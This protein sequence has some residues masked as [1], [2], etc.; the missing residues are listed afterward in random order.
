MDEIFMNVY[1]QVNMLVNHIKPSK[2][3]FIAV[4][5]VAPRAKANNQRDRRY[6][7]A[8][9][10][11]DSKEFL[12]REMQV[13]LEA[14]AMK[15]NSISPGT[16]FMFDLM[17]K[18]RF[19]IERKIHEDPA[20]RRLE[21][22]FSGGDVPGE[23]EQKIMEWIRG[24]KQSKDFDINESHCIYSNDADLVFLA[25]GLHLPKV[26]LV[27]E[28]RDFP[29]VQFSA[30]VRR[31]QPA[32][33][34]EFLFINLL[35]E[36][37]ELEFLQD[38]HRYTHP[39]DFERIIDD[40]ILVSFF[41]GNDFLHQL[42]CMSTKRGNYD[43]LLQTFKATLPTL[44]GY[45]SDKG[46]V[47]WKNFLVL[48]H[49]LQSLEPVMIKTTSDEMKDAV[50]DLGRNNRLIFEDQPK[51]LPQAPVEASAGALKDPPVAEPKAEEIAEKEKPTAKPEKRQLVYKGPKN[52]L[53]NKEKDQQREADEAAGFKSSLKTLTRGFEIRLQQSYLK[54]KEESEYLKQMHEDF[55]TKNPATIES[56]KMSLYQ[57]FFPVKS[58][59]DV[60]QVCLKYLEGV[61]F[62][63]RYYLQSCPSWTWYYPYILT[64][65]LSDLTATLQKHVLH[66]EPKFELS[67]PYKP[68]KQLCFILPR[69]SFGLL[70]KA[71][72]DKVLNDARCQNY[73]PTVISQL[74]PLD[75]VNE[76]QLTPIL[77][78]IIDEVIDEVISEIQEADL[79]EK[80]RFRNQLGSCWRFRYSES[81]EPVLFTSD[82]KGLPDFSESI[83]IEQYDYSQKYPID[84]SKLDYSQA[85]ATL[86][87]GFPSLK[88]IPSVEGTLVE[89]K[90]RAGNFMKMQLK[91]Y[92]SCATIPRSAKHQGY[93][94]YDYPFRKV[95][96]V[97]S[98]LTATE[99]TEDCIFGSPLL[100]NC[101]LQD[102]EA[103]FAYDMNK[104]IEKY[105]LSE[106][107]RDK[108]I[109]Y[110]VEDSLD[111]YYALAVRTAA[112][113]SQ[114][115]GLTFDFVPATEVVPQGLVMPFSQAAFDKLKV[116]LK[117]P[118]TQPDCGLAGTQ[119][120]NLEDGRRYVQQGIS[121]DGFS[122]K[123]TL[124]STKPN[125]SL[126]LVTETDLMQEDWIPVDSKLLG[127]LGLSD[128]QAAVLYYVMD[129]MPVKLDSSKTTI[130]NLC[131][132]LDIGLRFCNGLTSVLSS[133]QIVH[134]L[135]K[136]APLM[137]NR[138]KPRRPNQVHA[139]CSGVSER[140]PPLRSVAVA[141]SKAGAARLLLDL[142]SD[143]PVPEKQS[144]LL[145]RQENRGERPLRS[146]ALSQLRFMFPNSDPA[147]DL[148]VQIFR[149]YQWVM[150]LPESGFERV[151]ALSVVASLDP[152]RLLAKSRVRSTPEV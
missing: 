65:F 48:L 57:R 115:D 76:Y 122:V 131:G 2:R 68:F 59:A 3:L 50:F 144:G 33:R 19:F 98:V 11:Q 148:N 107:I 125:L 123:A 20:W 138:Q 116:Q 32:P 45:L 70:P 121:E 108:G 111:N 91:F 15:T 78:P 133:L 1:N 41:V 87:D 67:Q 149:I 89:I 54:L 64:P 73:F 53:T 13:T 80:E 99:L 145:D 18:M 4:D 39:F 151:R 71:Y 21:V 150:V 46:E 132:T 109:E 52:W 81:A 106:L 146:L 75:S 140:I 14:P 112:F 93:V 117:V 58:P 30:A 37:L 62:V 35:R 9:E 61:Q 97:G 126:G 143:R 96:Y 74:E 51:T 134:D 85:G 49:K 103:E 82:V 105:C 10:G 152:V 110:D 119:F 104:E 102:K 113:K 100:F 92:S 38:A 25:L 130:L 43:L 55:M 66:F 8:K 26:A 63:L 147:V 36:Y 17:E 139:G 29:D 95:G 31:E 141:P 16:E 22:V 124:A 128:D 12:T 69:G 7:S 23:G 5:G 47:C 129:S 101:L 56:A 94:F 90:R 86:E 137:Q 84:P 127:E 72:Q 6:C 77:Q 24:W 83:S 118:L 28:S 40:F 135:V 60:E 27:R 79:T 114:G 42:Y 120:I 88:L 136:Y 44:G 142:P 34:L